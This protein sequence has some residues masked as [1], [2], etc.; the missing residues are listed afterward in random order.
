MSKND[1]HKAQKSINEIEETLNSIS[2][3]Q[4]NED[5][6]VEKANVIFENNIHAF[7]KYFPEIADKFISH[8]PD[9]KFNLFLNPNGTA[10]FVDYDTG[11]PIYSDDPHTQSKEQIKSMLKNPILGKVDH[12]QLEFIKN[13]TNFIHIDLMAGIGSIYNEAQRGL[14]KAS[15]LAEYVPS[16]IIFGV[17]LGYYLDNFFDNFNAAYISVFEPNED[18]FFA[19][20][21]TFDWVDFLSKVDEAGSYLYFSIGVPEQEMYEA[22]YSRA[23]DIGAFSVASAL[24][25]QHYPSEAVNKLIAEFKDNFHQFFMGWGFFDDALL[26]IAHTLNNSQKSIN[27][28]KP[29]QKIVEKYN[30]YPIFIVA[31]GPSLDNDIENIKKFKEKVII[32]A[33][34]SATTALLKQGITP[35]F[36]V[37][38]ERTKAT[39]DFLTAFIPEQTRQKINLLVLNVMYPKV[40]D[41]F[42]WCGV[43]LK[44]N[45]AGTSLFHISEFLKNNR[46]TTTIGYSNP[47][48]GNTALSFFGS[49][50]FKNIY[51]F[52]TDNGYKDPN[53]H[54]SKGSYYYSGEGETIHAPLKM[55]GELVVPGNFGGN[56][57]TDHFMHTG[58]VQMERFLE[59]KS[60]IGM[61]CFN[62]SDGSAIKGSMPLK[63]DDILLEEFSFSK[64]EVIGHIKQQAFSGLDENVCL[65]DYLD[66]DE[67]EQLC[68]TMA[69]ILNKPTS[70]RKEALKQL[71]ESLRYLFSFKNHPR[72][73]HLFLLLEGESLY[74]TSV[75]ISLLYNFGD[76]TSIIPYYEKAKKLWIDF[77]ADAPQQYRQRWNELSDYSFDY[78]KPSVS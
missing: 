27:L 44:G 18:Y 71:L 42:G 29:S 8:E 41:L 4:Q 77:I 55:G 13:E 21:F 63:S 6:F 25:F 69:D 57:I 61:N 52:G 30:H 10:N 20:L 56:I 43:A 76:E 49:M 5:A 59:S 58:K 35:D 65:T 37:A 19:S 45:E 72:Y 68:N 15:S 50:E 47:L 36:H 38:L 53:H 11:V 16:A 22:L 73:T 74:V 64:N 26:S 78:S 28:L 40:L 2:K 3:K 32:V 51:L 46:I 1:L 66:F 14:E 48:V 62:C 70:N 24:F 60:D 31:N 33:C 34:N 9:N 17:G 54:H 7:R 39:E 75:L 12:T 67:F 23:N